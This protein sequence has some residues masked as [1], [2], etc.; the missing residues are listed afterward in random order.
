[1]NKDIF[2]NMQN[3]MTPRDETIRELHEKIENQTKIKIKLPR[4][5]MKMATVICSILVI[6]VWCIPWLKSSNDN[7]P[8]KPIKNIIN[9]NSLN[10]EYN[11]TI[12]FNEIDTLS[13]DKSNKVLLDKITY[14][15][16]MNYKQALEYYGKG[17]KPNNL[18]IDLIN[19]NIEKSYQIIYN[20][21]SKVIHDTN[22]FRFTEKDQNEGYNPLKRILAI[23]VSNKRIEDDCIYINEKE[24]KASSINNVKVML[25]HR[26]MD[27]GPYNPNEKTADGSNK[28][29]GYYDSYVAKFNYKGVDFNIVSKNLTKDEFIKTVVGIITTATKPNKKIALKKERFET[30]RDVSKDKI[31]SISK[32]SE[33]L[34]TKIIR[35]LTYSS[36]SATISTDDKEN[37]LYVSYNN[38][39]YDYLNIHVSPL[40]N[41]YYKNLVDI[42]EVEKYDITKYKPPFAETIPDELRNTMDRPIFK[43]SEIKKDVIDRRKVI[44]RGDVGDSSYYETMKFSVKCGDFII[45]YNIK[46][47]KIDSNKVVEMVKSSKYYQ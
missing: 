39:A 7:I 4:N 27:Y 3:Q 12:V 15:A 43:E 31:Y 42:D 45:D 21:E 14:R 38:N 32:L 1:M 41:I 17:I 28:P 25:G 44:T 37:R 2:K 19:D 29:A 30:F 11:N 22:V 40:L 6:L 47:N 8:K 10:K 9:P 23:E 16:K 26:L 18:P 35:N 5:I 20:Q 33:Y 13:T 46:M 34:P 24:M 36:G